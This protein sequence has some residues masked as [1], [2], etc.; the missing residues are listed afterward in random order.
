MFEKIKAKIEEL[1][2]LARKGKQPPDLSQFNDPLAEQVE[3]TPAKGGGTNI[4]T[5]KLMEKSPTRMAFRPTAGALFFYLIFLFVGLGVAVGIPVSAL[6]KGNFKPELLFPI[7]IG[8]VFIVIGGCLTYFGTNP[9]VFDTMNGYFWKGRKDPE[10]VFDINRI[11]HCTRLKEI[12]ALQ[13]LSEY[14]SGNKSSYYSYELNLI[15]EDGTRL[16]VVDHGNLKKLREDAAIL[17]SF[18]GK[19]VWDIARS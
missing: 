2:E 13:I 4:R 8:L 5:H 10:R 3:W 9:I 7:G 14:C 19:P 15:L 18:L 16:N 11:K 1:K 6:S 17:S 12:H